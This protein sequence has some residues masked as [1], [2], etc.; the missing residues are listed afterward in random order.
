MF[1][2]GTDPVHQTMNRV[3]QKLETAGIT[4]AIIGG[5]A[6]N[7]HGHRQ[8]TDDVDLL[9]TFSGIEELR[10]LFVPG[11]FERVPH[12]ARRY[13]DATNNVSI[14]FICAGM[15]PGSGKPGP[16]AH[17][18]PAAVSEVIDGRRVVNLRT[19]IQMKLAAR[20]FQDFAD[21]ISLIRVHDL[22]ESYA[23]RLHQSVRQAFIECLEAKRREDE[24]EAR[25]DE[26]MEAIMRKQQ[27]LKD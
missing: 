15:F 19:L 12:R 14:D 20:R 13:T 24:Y 16:I 17:P 11:D 25:Q 9:L 10:R 3:A 4:Y 6:V 8:T 5:M 23:E 1:F 21:V 2:Q 27:Y 22:D 7:A 18:H 26:Q